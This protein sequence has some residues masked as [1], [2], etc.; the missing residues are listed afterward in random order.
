M[1]EV[2]VPLTREGFGVTS[3]IDRW[4]TSWLT[5]LIVL[6]CFVVYATWAAF[7]GAHYRFGP[8]L[9]PFYS[10]E[11]WGNPLTAWIGG[12]PGWYPSWLIFSP[13]FFILPFPGGFRLTCYYYRGAYYKSFWSDPPSCTVGEP[14]KTYW[15]ERTLPLV[16]QNVH[17]YFMYIALFFIGDLAYDAW[18]GFW[19]NG[20][21]GMGVGSI[22][23][24]LDVIL[25]G[26]YTF[27][28]HAIRHR[29]GGVLDRLSGSRFRKKTYDCVSCLTARHMTWA[30]FSLCWVAFTDFYVRACS[31]GLIRDWRFF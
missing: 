18:N 11:L 13:A 28:C 24:L 20:H 10:P 27:G 8:Y 6:S 29:V 4:W 15:G 22:V 25:L 14:R 9:S 7:Q 21:F 23:L 31:M 3:R 26:G 16:L 30:W 2:D 19:F 17:R 1:P 12:K 5:V